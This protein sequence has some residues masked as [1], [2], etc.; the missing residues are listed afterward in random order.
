MI[1]EDDIVV[2]SWL[3]H[4]PQSTIVESVR[5]FVPCISVVL[6]AHAEESEEEEVEEDWIVSEESFNSDSF[7]LSDETV[8]EKSKSLVD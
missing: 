8:D 1:S 4:N 5:E 3:Y 2:E 7:V 6:E